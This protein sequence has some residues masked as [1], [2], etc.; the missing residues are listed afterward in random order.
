MA[1][2]KKKRQAPL[3][4]EACVDST[5]SLMKKLA[6]EG[7]AEGTVLLARRQTGGRGRMERRFSSPE[8][9]VYLSM[10]LRPRC[11][12]EE[13]LS[14]TPC[15][16]VAAARAV[17]RLCGLCCGVKWPND[18]LFEGKKLCGILCESVFAGRE[19]YLVLGL[20]LNVNT[21]AEAFPPELRET[22]ASLRDFVERELSVDEA[23][24][25]LIEELDGMYSRWQEDRGAFLEEYRALCV[26]LGRSVSLIRN[27]AASPALAVDIDENYALVAEYPDGTREHISYGEV[28]LREG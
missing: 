4:R 17:E 27:G 24:A 5:N 14:L 20:G 6:L 9:G 19:Q 10:L 28:S 3:L 15:A 26:N 8:G 12:P 18:L 21:P 13:S 11:T 16:A 2:E 25:L 7:A 1:A 23:A 22:A